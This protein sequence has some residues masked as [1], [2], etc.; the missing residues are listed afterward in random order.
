MTRGPNELYVSGGAGS[1]ELPGPVIVKIQSD[2]LK[3]TWNTPLANSNVTDKWLIPG[4]GRSSQLL[5][6]MPRFT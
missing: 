4:A 2:S 3:E 5:I 1:L 6:P